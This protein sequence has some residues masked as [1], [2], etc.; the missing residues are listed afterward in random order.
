ML[1][2]SH[3][4]SSHDNT[5]ASMAKVICEHH[6]CSS[7]GNDVPWGVIIHLSRRAIL[8]LFAAL[9]TEQ[10]GFM[11]LLVVSLPLLRDFVAPPAA[12]H[13][14]QQTDMIRTALSERKL[15]KVGIEGLKS[16]HTVFATNERDDS[17]SQFEKRDLVSFI[18][19]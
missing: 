16:A 17:N 4:A 13:I 8:N 6:L 14:Q 1:T 7:F 18:Q 19:S 12:L 3:K 9:V 11:P 2:C 10:S 15:G 5:A